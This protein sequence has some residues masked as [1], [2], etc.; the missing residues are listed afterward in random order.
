MSN[1][2]LLS[3]QTDQKIST[4]T[5]LIFLIIIWIITICVIYIAKKRRTNKQALIAEYSPPQNIG[6]VFA[7]YI[8]A[9]GR[10]GGVA[11]D[12]SRSGLQIVMLVSFYEQG[13]LTK[14]KFVDESDIE[15]EIN[16]DYK[17]ITCCE[18]EKIF[19]ESLLKT[20]GLSG[21]LTQ[22]LGTEQYPSS[23]DG[24]IEI[25]N[26]WIEYWNKSLYELALSRGYFKKSGWLSRLFSYYAFSLTFGIFFS[27]FLSLIPFIGIWICVPLVL[28]VVLLFISSGLFAKIIYSE[29]FSSLTTDD[30][31]KFISIALVLSWFAW[32]IIYGSRT[33]DI[34][35][36]YSVSAYEIAEKIKGYELYLNSVDR[37]RLS[38][39]RNRNTTDIHTSFAWLIIFGLAT[40][41]HWNQWY[42]IIGSQKPKS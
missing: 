26:I 35:T 18:D 7:R 42:E 38:F 16:P 19:L 34:V 29:I 13:L 21:K 6:P 17:N 36:T 32:L 5:M 10:Q 41:E 23:R 3:F 27:V 24:Y 28:P 8:L 12:V 11:G 20:I 15:Y 2:N 33:R 1:L 4:M 14:L 25:E 9:S 22:D 30:S 39:S 37:N 31:A 40:D